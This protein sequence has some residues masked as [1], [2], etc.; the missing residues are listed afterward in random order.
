M[1]TF[2]SH[3]TAI[4]GLQYFPRFPKTPKAVIFGA[5]NVG[6][7]IFA[8]RLAI[9]LGVPAVSMRD[10]YK[11]ILTFEEFYGSETFYRKVINLLKNYHE[12]DPEDIKRINKEIEDNMVPEK[13][14]TLTKYTELGFVLYDYPGSIR[15]CEK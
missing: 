6:T 13:L 9:D 4:K 5:P 3:I 8:H 1:K 10:I 11:N 14:L 12:K 2:N 7:S 15:Q